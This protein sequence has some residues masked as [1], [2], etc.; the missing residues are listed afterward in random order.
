[1][2][3]P[4]PIH[5]LVLFRDWQ[6][7][8]IPHLY[9]NGAPGLHFE[10]ASSGEPIAHATVN[11]PE[12]AALSRERYTLVWIKHWSENEG[13]LEVLL[14]AGIIEQTGLFTDSGYVDDIPLCKVVCPYLLQGFDQLYADLASEEPAYDTSDTAGVPMAGEGS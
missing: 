7:I 14:D 3:T 2:N 4:M 13:I 5:P 6:C 10:D 8:V 12:K 11:L 1:M 9:P